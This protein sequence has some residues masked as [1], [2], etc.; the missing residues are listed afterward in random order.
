MISGHVAANLTEW[1]DRDFLTME[2]IEAVRQLIDNAC[3]DA[4]LAGSDKGYESGFT[5][6]VFASI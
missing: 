4:Y 2:Q 1:L 6:G 3:C 5:D